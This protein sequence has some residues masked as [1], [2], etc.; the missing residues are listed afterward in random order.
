[1]INIKGNLPNLTIS[2]LFEHSGKAGSMVSFYQMGHSCTLLC[3]MPLTS[4][5]CNIRK[6]NCNISKKIT[7]PGCHCPTSIKQKLL[8]QC[9]F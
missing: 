3:I 4:S 8:L 6:K 9:K 1:M 2:R 7:L 5:I